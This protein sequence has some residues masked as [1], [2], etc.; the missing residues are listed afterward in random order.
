MMVLATNRPEDL[1]AAILD[2][3]DVSIQVSLPQ[4]EQRVE[5]V[6]LYMDL[7]LV[8][9]AKASVRKGLS[10]LLFGSRG[11]SSVHEDCRKE[12]NLV[13]IA[14]DTDGFSGREISKLFISAQYAMFLAEDHKLTW[15]IL[16][17]TVKTKVQEHRIKSSG[18]QS[19]MDMDKDDHKEP[20]KQLQHQ[21]SN[22]KGGKR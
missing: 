7:H 2:R 5:L 22:G 12:S 20:T 10:K 8:R 4:E 6:K 1:D 19:V 3:I 15:I 21:H 9:A 14:R 16:E 18:F 13:K 11:E 17:Q